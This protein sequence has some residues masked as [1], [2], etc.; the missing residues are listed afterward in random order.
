MNFI[1]PLPETKNVN[2]YILNIVDKISKILRVIPI[3][4]NYDAI[5]VGKKL[6]EHVSRSYC[7]PD[8]IILDRDSIFISKF[9]KTLFGT[10]NVKISLSTAYHP[11]TDGKTEIVNRKLEEM[12]C[13][14]INYEKD[15]WD[16]H[17]VEFEVAYKASVGSTTAHTLFFFSYGIHH[18]TI[19]AEPI[20]P[21]NHPS[22]QEYL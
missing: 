8:K 16:K 19:P 18:R 22:I 4:K 13:C 12:I 6:V 17:L 9:W 10:L 7:L 20:V 1:A 2:R 5:V 15:N 14:F 21:R 3:L 11:Q